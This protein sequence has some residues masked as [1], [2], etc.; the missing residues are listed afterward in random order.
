MR[1]EVSRALS[2]QDRGGKFWEKAG[3]D[4][5]GVS[6]E[7]TCLGIVIHIGRAPSCRVLTLSCP[8]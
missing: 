8:L 2:R 5:S 7:D 3:H 6:T 4:L 1:E